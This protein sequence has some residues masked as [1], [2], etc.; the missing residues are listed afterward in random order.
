MESD[1]VDDIRLIIDHGNEL[2]HGIRLTY[3]TLS[4]NP[5]ARLVLPDSLARSKLEPEATPEGPAG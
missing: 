2:V 4:E 3:Y 5:M 1:E